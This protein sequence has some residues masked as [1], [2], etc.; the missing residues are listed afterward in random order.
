MIAIIRV[1]GSIDVKGD[2]KRTMR[3]LRLKTCNQ[4]VVVQETPSVKGMIKKSQ[5]FT[6]F[7]QINESTLAKLLQ[8]RA[9]IAGNKRLTDEFVKEKKTSIEQIA[10]EV[11]S[12]KAKLQDFGI[13][14]VFRLSPPRKGFERQ[15]IKKPFKAGG[16]LGN[17]GEKINNLIERM[18]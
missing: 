7:G 13:K 3:M 15:G 8:K 1:R 12:G 11:I 17:R 6:T 9:R 10:K 2:I 16:A 5:D 4:M 18:M 14:P